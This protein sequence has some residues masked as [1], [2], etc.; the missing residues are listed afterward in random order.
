MIDDQLKRAFR[1]HMQEARDRE[2]K[3]QRGQIAE[4]PAKVQ[5]DRDALMRGKAARALND[6]RNDVAQGVNRYPVP[7]VPFGA[8]GGY[9]EDADGLRYVPFGARGGWREEADGLRY[10]GRV[11]PEFRRGPFGGRES[12]GWLNIPLGPTGL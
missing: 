9:R 5:R 3:I 10:V 12:E 1:W 6:A 7:H 11:S 4:F 2:Q 8:R